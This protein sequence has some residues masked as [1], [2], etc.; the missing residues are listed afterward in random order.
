VDSS[1][2]VRAGS[3]RGAE[4]PHRRICEHPRR[5]WLPRPGV[6][7]LGTPHCGTPLALADALVFGVFSR[8]I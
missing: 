1:E 2:H 8:A 3:A 5:Q 7:T 6:V 4:P